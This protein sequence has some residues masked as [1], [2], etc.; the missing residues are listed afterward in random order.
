[1]SLDLAPPIVSRGVRGWLRENLFSTWTNTLV[2]IVLAVILARLTTAVLD[3]AITTARWGVVTGNLRLFLIGQYPLAEAWRVWLCLAILSVLSGLSAG[4]GS[5]AAVRT[6]AGWLAAGQLMLA[7]LTLV[8][9]MEPIAAIL[10]AANAAAVWASFAIALRV[11]VR[12]RGLSLAWLA[13]LPT[14]TILLA[15]LGGGAV[16]PLVPTTQWGGLL[17]TFL[18]AIVVL[19]LW[20]ITR[21]RPAPAPATGPRS[22]PFCGDPVQ[23]TAV[24]CMHCG[25]DI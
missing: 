9:G 20:L 13:S 12:R 2:T 15:G 24:V 25:R 4:R 16:L 11:P 7:A 19:P 3:W 18:L 5:G 8:S 17:L 1:M 14:T 23:P 10:L 21:P 22:C 6:L